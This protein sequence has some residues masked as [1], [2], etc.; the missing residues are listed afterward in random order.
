MA[1]IAS[2]TKLGAAFVPPAPPRTP[3]SE[4]TRARL[5]Q[6]AIALFIDRGYSDVS[7]RDLAAAAGLTKGAIYGHFR[8]KGQL[9]VEAIRYRLA[10][11]DATTDFEAAIADHDQ[12][13]RLMFDERR[14]ELRLL[15]VDAAAAARHDA[16]VAAGLAELYRERHTRISDALAGLP[17]P[18]AGAFVIAA[19]NA[20]IGMKEAVGVSKPRADHL[21][22]VIAAALVG[23]GYLPEDTD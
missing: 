13:V 8:S 6:I 5:M 9:L 3:K 1:G 2:V 14:R 17:D 19:L 7:M 11:Q 4:Q 15:E 16:D 20:G 23:M 18:D 22:R 10:E 12:G 21:A